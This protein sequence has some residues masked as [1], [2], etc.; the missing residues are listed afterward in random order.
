MKLTLTTVTMDKVDGWPLAAAKLLNT[1]NL[2][3]EDPCNFLGV[4]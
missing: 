2:H 1:I 4:L 3:D